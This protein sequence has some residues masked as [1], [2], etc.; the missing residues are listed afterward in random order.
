VSSRSV[1]LQNRAG[2]VPVPARRHERRADP[3]VGLVQRR[4]HHV[5][6]DEPSVVDTRVGIDEAFA[7]LRLESGAPR[8]LRKVR[9]ERARERLTASQ[10]VV[11]E[12]SRPQH[13][14]GTQ[15]RLVRQHERQRLDEMRRLPQH[16]FALRERFVHQPELVLLEVAQA[17]VDQLRA[18]LR[19]G[20]SDVALLDD[21]AP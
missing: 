4:V 14:R 7:E 10:V 20:G 15:M 6:H 1:A 13:P 3:D 12:Q 18:P 9:G 11:Q 2:A 19:R 5:A 16:H 21:A 17:A 8:R